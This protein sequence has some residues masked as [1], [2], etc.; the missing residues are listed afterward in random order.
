[1]CGQVLACVR[2]CVS[3]DAVWVYAV[4][5]I[6]LACVCVLCVAPVCVCVHVCICVYV[7]ACVL[8][9]VVCVAVAAAALASTPVL[10]IFH[11]MAS[12]RLI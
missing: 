5:G 6:I 10:R 2:V 9:L 12:A 7:C 8:I 1:M 11:T 4:C 3:L